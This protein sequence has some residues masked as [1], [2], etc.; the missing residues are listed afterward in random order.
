MKFHLPWVAHTKGSKDP[1]FKIKAQ[2]L[3]CFYSEYFSVKLHWSYSWSLN[4][5]FLDFTFW[6]HMHIITGRPIFIEIGPVYFGVYINWLFPKQKIWNEKF[7]KDMDLRRG[8]EQNR[9]ESEGRIPWEWYKAACMTCEIEGIDVSFWK[10]R[11]CSDKF[12][13]IRK[14]ID[15]SFTN[16]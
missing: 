10:L 15:G 13:M 5:T 7:N 3:F 16:E 12:T 1:I 9:I 6:N 4:F 11:F 14:K 8:D 2:D